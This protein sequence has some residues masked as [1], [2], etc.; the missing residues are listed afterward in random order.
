MMEGRN[1]AKNF[2]TNNQNRFSRQDSVVDNNLIHSS[3]SVQAKFKGSKNNSII[4]MID[5][6]LHVDRVVVPATQNNFKQTNNESKNGS[7]HDFEFTNDCDT[8]NDSYT[9]NHNYKPLNY[10]PGNGFLPRQVKKATAIKK[11]SNKTA[12]NAL[13]KYLNVDKQRADAEKNKFSKAR[14]QGPSKFETVDKRDLLAKYGGYNRKREVDENTKNSN[15]KVILSKKPKIKTEKY[16]EQPKIGGPQI[17]EQNIE[18]TIPEPI[19]GDQNIGE[20]V[21]ENI[22]ENP[23]TNPPTV[24]PILWNPDDKV[25][26]RV[27]GKSE[28]KGKKVILKK[29]L[30]DV[31][32]F[33]KESSGSSEGSCSD[34]DVLSVKSGERLENF[35]ENE[36]DKLEN[37]VERGLVSEYVPGE[38][39]K[40]SYNC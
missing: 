23:K 2:F 36:M 35:D 37:G 25:M 21:G 22:G 17:G 24:D 26:T 6:T 9:N 34:I 40:T 12:Q 39:L 3:T 20:N 31:D 18:P 8:K 38:G 30:K 13:S 28:K 27:S 29:F 15:T 1:L 10:R 16:E 4:S 14:N 19:I 5:S 33:L 32:Q 7:K 11:P